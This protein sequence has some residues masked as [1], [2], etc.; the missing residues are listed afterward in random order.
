MAPSTVMNNE[1]YFKPF[2]ALHA[3]RQEQLGLI[4]MR[5]GFSNVTRL[6]TTLNGLNRPVASSVALLVDTRF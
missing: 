6:T 3:L 5:S 1:T 4:L 2:T